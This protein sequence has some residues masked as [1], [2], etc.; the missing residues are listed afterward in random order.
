MGNKVMVLKS[1]KNVF[2]EALIITITIFLVGLF[3]GMTIETTNSNKISQLYTQ[4]EISLTDATTAIQLLEN[5]QI[6]CDQL[7]QHYINLAD[8]IYEEAKQ[9]ELYEDSG[10]IT[11]TMKLLHKKYDLLRTILWASTNQYLKECNDHQIIVYLYDYNSEN[12]ET[13]ALQNVWSKILTE[14]KQTQ[15]DTILI[16]IATDQ[17]LTSLDIILKDYEL[18]QIPAI[19]INNEKI[20]YE[21]ENITTIKNALND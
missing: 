16:P 11:D 12:L 5:S 14:L 13:K 9:L 4:S 19:I 15:K 21:I 17:N 18:K 1:K 3:L 8:E 2:W 10:K 20:L 6:D 7:T